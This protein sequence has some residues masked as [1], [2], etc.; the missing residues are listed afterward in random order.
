MRPWLLLPLL[1]ACA[2]A[3]VPQ[4]RPDQGWA[5]APVSAATPPAPATRGLPWV[6]APPT[7]SDGS[8]ASQGARW[9]RGGGAAPD[10]LSTLSPPA[11]R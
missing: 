9:A 11:N 2:E 5:P 8:S 7:W 3:P 10:T 6:G 4:P 1:A